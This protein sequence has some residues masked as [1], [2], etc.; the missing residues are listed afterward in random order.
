MVLITEATAAQTVGCFRFL[1]Y[2][3][4]PFTMVGGGKQVMS[5]LT[6]MCQE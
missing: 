6:L 5:T 2:C 4:S 3:M 1:P